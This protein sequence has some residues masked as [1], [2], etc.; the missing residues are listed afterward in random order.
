MKMRPI[1]LVRGVLLVA[2]ALGTFLSSPASAHGGD[3]VITVDQ[4]HPAQGSTHYFV[5]MTWED[6]D[7]ITDGSLTATP[8]A[9]DGTE[10][11]L[12]VLESSGDGIYQGAVAMDGPGTWTVRFTTVD[13]P[14]S[15]ETT[16]V[17]EGPTTTAAPTTTTTAVPET[18]APATSEQTVT[19]QDTTA[20]EAAAGDTESDDDSSSALPLV[21]GGIVLVAVLAGGAYLL[22][23]RK[24]PTDGDAEDPT[25]VPTD[26]PA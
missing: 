21:I 25:D 13:P 5:R 20:D 22:T 3:P 24:P 26:T 1:L 11:D 6:G 10:G 2:L 4:V 14:G 15:M 23:R 18:T 9:P 7:P 17:V 12:V 19:T 8:I 16:Q